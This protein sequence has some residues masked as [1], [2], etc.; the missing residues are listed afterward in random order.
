MPPWTWFPPFTPVPALATSWA[1]Q[2][3]WSTHLPWSG[4]VAQRIAPQLALDAITGQA[5]DRALEQRVLA[6]VASYGRQLAL[7][8]DLLLDLA[9][10]LPP[11]GAAGQAA[12]ERL[13]EIGQ[14]IQAL[15]VSA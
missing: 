10:Q 5:G 13:A 4:D 2:F 8:H 14:R 9:G 7:I 15:K 6:E 3:H 1:P 12:R 11:T